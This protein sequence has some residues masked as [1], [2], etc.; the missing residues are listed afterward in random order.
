MKELGIGAVGFRI[1]FFD[2][3]DERNCATSLP[4]A[5]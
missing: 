5:E 3:F 2:S 4:D 1:Y